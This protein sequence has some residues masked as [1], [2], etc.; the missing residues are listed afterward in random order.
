[1]ASMVGWYQWCVF[2]MVVVEMRVGFGA[3]GV[4]FLALLIFSNYQQFISLSFSKSE[5]VSFSDTS[6]LFLFI[7]LSVPV[8]VRVSFNK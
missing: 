3:A 5:I 7:K 1:M 2:F 8:E 4:A 6:V